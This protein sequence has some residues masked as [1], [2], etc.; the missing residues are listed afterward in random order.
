MFILFSQECMFFFIFLKHRQSVSLYY[1][2]CNNHVAS[3]G[4]YTE[5]EKDCL[6]SF[7]H[8]I[9]LLNVIQERG[10]QHPISLAEGGKKELG[11]MGLMRNRAS[12]YCCETFKE[13]VISQPAASKTVTR[14]TSERD[15][16]RY[17][18]TI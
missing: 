14:I 18:P 7:Y 1:K 13:T 9:C 12:E 4:K 2:N 8:T 11:N 3:E 10:F 5:R 16:K 15:K 17:S 6:F